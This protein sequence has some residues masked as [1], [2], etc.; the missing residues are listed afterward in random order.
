MGLQKV[1]FCKSGLAGA[2]SMGDDVHNCVERSTEACCRSTDE[3]KVN[4]T[5]LSASILATIIPL[6]SA[7]RILVACDVLQQSALRDTLQ[8]DLQIA[9][10]PPELRNLIEPIW[11]SLKSSFL[12]K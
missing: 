12:D 10:F 5:V 7:L 9:N 3:I 4:T 11:D 1:E 6:I 8:K 2:T